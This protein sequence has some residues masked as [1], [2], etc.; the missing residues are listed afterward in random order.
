MIPTLKKKK[1]GTMLQMFQNPFPRIFDSQ[2]YPIIFSSYAM[3]LQCPFSKRCFNHLLTQTRLV[4]LYFFIFFIFIPQPTHFDSEIDKTE[5]EPA[6]NFSYLKELLIPKVRLL[7]DGLPFRSEGYSRTKSVL[8]GKFG[9]SNEIAAVHIQGITPGCLIFK[10]HI[11]TEYMI[12]M[13][14]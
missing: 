13:K 9:K 11:Q 2:R 10:I 12:S 8:L 1:R 7:I 14:S 3:L 5:I 4:F 6:C